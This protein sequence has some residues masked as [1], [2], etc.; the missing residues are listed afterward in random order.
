MNALPVPTNAQCCVVIYEG[1]SV[2]RINTNMPIRFVQ[3][4]APDLTLDE[5]A[6]AIAMT[7]MCIYKFQEEGHE[8]IFVT[9]QTGY[10]DV[11][12]EVTYCHY[13]LGFLGDRDRTEEYIF[14]HYNILPSDYDTDFFTFTLPLV[15]RELGY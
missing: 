15:K 2:P 6:S 3:V 12:I 11:E 14:L 9:D 10:A 1:E 7:V 5:Y 4:S 13:L 8:V